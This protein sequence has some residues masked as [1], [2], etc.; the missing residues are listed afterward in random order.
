MQSFVR[1]RGGF[2]FAACGAL[3]ESL[4][5]SEGDDD[6]SE[7]DAQLVSWRDDPHLTHSDWTLVVVTSEFDSR[8]YHVHKNILSV[9][10]RSSK[11]F[12]NVFL[13][14]G[15]NY[16]QPHT[17]RIELDEQD[18]E[19]FPLLLD[20]IYNTRK[21]N[22]SDDDSLSIVLGDDFTTNNAVTLRHLARFFDCESLMLAVNK[23]IQDDLSPNTGPIYLTQ[24][25]SY[26]DKR[27]VESAKRMC[28]ENFAH[29]EA[30]A[31]VKLPLP[32][33]RSIIVS[34]I[35]RSQSSRNTRSEDE[36]ALS[37]QVSEVVCQYFEKHPKTLTVKLLL[38]LTEE[39]VM[40]TIA[41]EPAI[42]FTALAKD[43]NPQDFSPNSEEWRGLVALCERCAKAVVDEYGWKD[44]NVSSAVEE[45]LNG[46]ISLESGSKMDSLLFATSFA[47][48]LEKAQ[49]DYKSINKS[50]SDTKKQICDL[51]KENSEFRAINR[52]MK[53]EVERYKHLLEDTKKELLLLKQH[54][55][56]RQRK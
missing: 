36:V 12:A 4:F 5:S 45:Y 17:T 2:S 20:F 44:F 11:Y 8:K 37:N 10:P 43:L 40:P 1:P 3:A 31:L 6:V 24:A 49:H 48:A 29:L 38:E 27:L 23:F 28:I 53:K 51:R 21:R 32:L 34:V 18:A 47:A 54:T 15:K 41:P 22:A 16:I 46:P 35:E 50:S 14:Q 7:A 56:H 33:F 9:G 26:Q 42:G 25:Y 19:S 55:Q 30:Q 13:E 52:S 39:S